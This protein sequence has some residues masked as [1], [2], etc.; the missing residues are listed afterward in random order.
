MAASFSQFYKKKPLGE[1][2]KNC[3]ISLGNGATTSKKASILTPGL[4]FRPTNKK[5][6]RGDKNWKW[7]SIIQTNH[8]GRRERN[9]SK[10][11]A[12]GEKRSQFQFVKKSPERMQLNHEKI[13]DGKKLLSH[14]K[15]LEIVGCTNNW[16]NV[17]AR[18]AYNKV[19]DIRDFQTDSLLSLFQVCHPWRKRKTVYRRPHHVWKQDKLGLENMCSRIDSDLCVGL[20]YWGKP[21]DSKL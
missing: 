6:E 11:E 10:K 8:E 5:V 21:L 14:D 7:V 15:T 12:K 9:G 20:D 13:P 3:Q 4:F 16:R 2:W 19:T 18:R 1:L 17:F